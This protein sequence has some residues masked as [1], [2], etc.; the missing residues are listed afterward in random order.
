[1]RMRLIAWTMATM[2]LASAADAQQPITVLTGG[3]SGVYYPLG[4]TVAK[5]Y[6]DIPD[7]RVQVQ[8]TDGSVEN[9]M[10]LQQGSAQIAFALGDSLRDA[11]AGDAEAGFNGK[12]DKLRVIGA[13]Y[14]SYIQIVA[15]KASGI[16]TLAD[17]K[18]RSLSVGDVK[19]GTDLNAR[20]IIAAA[21]LAESDLGR[22][23]NLA[24]KDSTLAMNN[25]QLDATLQSAGLGVVSLK[26]LSAA[27]EITMVAVPKDVVARMG[28]PFVPGIIPANTY[29]GQDTDTPTATVMNYLVTSSA[30]SDDLAYQLTR[31]VYESL[32][33]LAVAHFVGSEIR[34]ETAAEGGPVPLHPGAIRFYREVGLLK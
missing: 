25:K 9:L 14:P 6:A 20:A 13:L 16:R 34:R 19:S 7:S 1:M 15:T 10:R 17:L 2:A 24:F 11:W 4:V 22:I 32:P 33:Q 21:G 23:D 8:T 31:L 5:I 27:T 3:I 30:V 29:I 26:E 28:A 12:L 18:G